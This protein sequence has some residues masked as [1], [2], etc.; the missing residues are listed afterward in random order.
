MQ[1][2]ELRGWLLSGLLVT[3]MLLA[4]GLSLGRGLLEGE[5]TAYERGAALAR[6]HHHCRGTFP[7]AQYVARA[8]SWGD[9]KTC[10]EI[11]KIDVQPGS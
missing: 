10:A 6:L 5:R 2:S 3:V 1:A 11:Q 7:S 9:P 8:F 4:I